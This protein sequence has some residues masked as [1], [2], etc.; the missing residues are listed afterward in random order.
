MLDIAYVAA[1]RLD[2]FCG[3]NL[4]PW[5]LAAA[6]LMV[7]EAGGLVVDLSGEQGWLDSGDVI[8]ASPKLFPQLLN[9]LK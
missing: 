4:K 8:A 1:G 9:H 3:V 2:G 6:C 5:D 7:T